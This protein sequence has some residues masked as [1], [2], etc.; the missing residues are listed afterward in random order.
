M[1][2]RV[3]KVAM[4]PEKHRKLQ[5]IETQEILKFS[6]KAWKTH[7]IILSLLH[8]RNAVFN[9]NGYSCSISSYFFHFLDMYTGKTRNFFFLDLSS[10]R[11]LKQCL[12]ILQEMNF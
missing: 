11:R 6:L 7:R 12:I 8:Q 3:S 10:K 1:L 9:L 5:N 4:P 2:R